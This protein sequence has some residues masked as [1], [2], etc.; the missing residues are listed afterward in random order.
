MERWKRSGGLSLLCR[1]S[2]LFV[3]TLF[4]SHCS[5]LCFIVCESNKR[6]LVVASQ[7]VM[8]ACPQ[9]SRQYLG[10]TTCCLVTMQDFF[11]RPRL[12]LAR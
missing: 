5:W 4:V 1:Q 10:E 8:T 6:V 2:T 11:G 3:N 9:V 12:S 7:D